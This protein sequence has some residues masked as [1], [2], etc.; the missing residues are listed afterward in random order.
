MGGYDRTI[1]GLK[2]TPQ[3]LRAAAIRPM[4][5]SSDPNRYGRVEPELFERDFDP[6]CIAELD[7]SLD[8][9]G[10][11]EVLEALVADAPGQRQGIEL[12]VASED[13]RSLQRHLHTIKGTLRLL[14]AG[15]LAD[16]FSDAEHALLNGAEIAA[17]SAD[18]L[19]I[20]PRYERLLSTAHAALAMTPPEVAGGAS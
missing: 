12:A 11:E 2:S 6:A 8:R 3:H 5:T 13:R 19:A 1:A 15:S 17:L 4:P 10:T 7:A 16:L 20:L 18:V 9:S 14:K